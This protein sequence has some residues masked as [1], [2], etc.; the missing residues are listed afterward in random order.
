MPLGQAYDLLPKR[1][2][3]IRQRSV[4]VRT[5]AHPDHT[6]RMALA[7]SPVIHAAHPIA[8]GRC[9]HD[10]FLSTSRLTSFSRS[11]SVNSF[12]S[13]LFSVSNYLSRL[14]SETLMP[15][16]LLRQR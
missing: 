3:L 8:V 15:P 12:L 13:R 4:A 6:Q 5:C 11:D 10:F 16:N 1:L 14:A 9:A 2:V 7:Q